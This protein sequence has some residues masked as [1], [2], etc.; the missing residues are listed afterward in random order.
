MKPQRFRIGQEVTP[1]K[2]EWSV[3]YNVRIPKFGEVY[4]V[5]AYEICPTTNRNCIVLDLIPECAWSDE[6]FAPI[7]SDSVLEEEL[8]EITQTIEA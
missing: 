5:I 4:K 2:K 7:I 1:T 8:R 3:L 6:F